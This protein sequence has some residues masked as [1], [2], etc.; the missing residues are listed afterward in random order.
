M[1]DS[2]GGEALLTLAHAAAKQAQAKGAEH[3]RVSVSRA[4]GVEV[5]WRDGQVERVQER[6]RRGLSVEL[7]VDGRYAAMS[8]NDLRPEAVDRFLDEAVDMTRL[9]EPD[10][11][12]CL[13]D[14][15]RYAGRA[16]IDLESHDPS[17][18]L[19]TSDTRRAVAEELETLVRQGAGDLPIVSVT[20]GVDDDWGESARVHTNGFEGWRE[21]THF[22]RSVQVTVRE[23]DGRRPMGWSYTVRRHQAELD[24]NAKIA[25]EA[26]E[27]ARLQLGA[28]KL[29][30]GRYT[31]V[32]DPRAVPRLLGAFL[33]PI[34]G[35]A[36]QQKR[37]LWDGRL[38]DRIASPLLTLHDDPWKVRGLAS[39][40]WDGDGFATR[41]RPIIEAGV[42]ATY[43]IDDYYARKMGVEAT[44]GSTHGLRW[45]Y[46]D[47]ALTGL[48]ADVGQGVYLDRF[49]GGNSNETT[50][51]LSLGCAGRI[52]RN[53][54]LA[55]PV[56]EV[57][58]GGHFGQ[59]W[60]ALVAVGNDPDPNSSSGAPS[61]VF[62]G[63]QLSGV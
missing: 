12:R 20:S 7:F 33:A 25:R 26:V 60:E 38:G 46:G 22:S 50:G 32:V 43:L 11:H 24:A 16:E 55:E 23:P 10:P 41:P 5:E 51:E 39:A 58:L 40:L 59:L 9:L 3:A 47:K 29:D 45:T 1:S 56:T 27:R 30:T 36:L 44:G 18:A 8:T 57:N 19:V 6:T 37:S 54:Q 35:A 34:S 13:P 21:G 53:G 49:L 31:I 17:Q 52:I 48:V 63:V 4:R 62:E 28:G 42:L 14:P 2:R 15:A 61:C